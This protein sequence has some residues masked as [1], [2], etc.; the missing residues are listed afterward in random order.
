MVHSENGFLLS[1]IKYGDADAVL[2]SFTKE[3]GFR[4]YFIK[5][6]FTQ[7]S[8]K[9]SYL[10]PLNELNFKIRDKSSSSM[11][12]VLSI[13]PL[14]IVESPGSK[15]DSVLFF[16]SEF[17]NHILRDE[18]EGH[19]VYYEV[20]KLLTEIENRNYSAHLVFMVKLLKV[21][22]VAPFIS[23]G[24]FL[25]AD[26]GVFT[27]EPVNSLYSEAVSN[28][29]KNIL[30]ESEPYQIKIESLSRPAVLDSILFYYSC[31]HSGFKTPKS[32]EIIRQLW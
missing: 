25:D 4:S 12:E 18:T 26:G 23:E 3:K 29:W 32:L 11:P 19:L 13:E 1:Y 5:S 7:K 6:V 14:K 16:V 28:Y 8:R 10:Q 9:K 20:C 27:D 17:L 24:K 2:H 30:S 15:S 21:L 22:G 31:H